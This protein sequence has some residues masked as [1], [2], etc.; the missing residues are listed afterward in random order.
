MTID[1]TTEAIAKLDPQE[2]IST[3]R[4]VDPADPALK[5]VDI[6]VIA[7]EPLLVARTLRA[8]ESGVIGQRSNAVGLQVRGQLINSFAREAVNDTG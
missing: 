6:D 3:L 5:D 7:R 4:Q 1:L 2:L 8:V